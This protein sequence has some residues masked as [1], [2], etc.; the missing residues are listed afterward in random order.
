MTA[1]WTGLGA[2]PWDSEVAEDGRETRGNYMAYKDRRDK[3]RTSSNSIFEAARQVC[4]AYRAIAH[5][6]TEAANR[7]ITT[8]MVPFHARQYTFVPVIVTTAR[9]HLCEFAPE[10]VSPISGSLPLDRA[11]LRE[12]SHLRY[13]FALPPALQWEGSPS[14]EKDSPDWREPYIRQWITVINAAHFEAFLEQYA[15]RV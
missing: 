13:E 2:F 7:T 11:R 6:E 14:I 4:L 8:D 1:A 10:D 15:H 12:V 5:E 9:L 3:T